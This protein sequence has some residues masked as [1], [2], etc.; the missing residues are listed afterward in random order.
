VNNEQ[1]RIW[2]EVVVPYFKLTPGIKCMEGLWG[3]MDELSQDMYS[4]GGDLALGSH[5]AIKT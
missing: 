1:E 5:R 2:K 4:P 3:T